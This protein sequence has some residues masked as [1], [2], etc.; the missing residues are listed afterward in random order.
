[1]KLVTAIIKPFKLD[2][3]RQALSNLGTQGI[4]VTE[5]KGFGRQKGHTE[6]YRGAEYIVDFLPKIKIEAAVADEHVPLVIEAIEQSARTGKI[7]D[8]K[9]FVSA[10]EQ[11]VRIRTGEDGNE[12]L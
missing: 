9:I 11:V 4:T 2:E 8:G 12:A 1:M 3:V 5:V 10:L 7:G 6:L